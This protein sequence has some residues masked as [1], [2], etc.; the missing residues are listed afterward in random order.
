M[1][2]ISTKWDVY[3]LIVVMDVAL[4]LKILC[5]TLSFKN[6]VDFENKNLLPHQ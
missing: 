1:T 6:A 3:I 2:Q 4:F 5:V